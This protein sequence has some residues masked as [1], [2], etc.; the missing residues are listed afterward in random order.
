M[1]GKHSHASLDV[2]RGLAALVVFAAHVGEV[3]FW[4]FTGLNDPVAAWV[5]RASLGAVG[6]FFALS[7]HLI[8]KS[9][10]QNIQKNGRFEPGEYLSSR[11]SR[12]YPPLIGAIAVSLVVMGL[13]RGFHL[14]GSPAV[15]YGVPG[16]LYASRTVLSMHP[17]EILA[18]LTMVG[19][20]GAV[21]GPLWSLYAE[22]QIYLLAMCAACWWRGSRLAAVLST[23]LALTAILYL[24]DYPTWTAIWG[25]GAATA[26]AG[27]HVRD[28]GM[29]WPRFLIAAGGCSYSL[30]ILHF[31][32]LLLI[33]SA[34]QNWVGRDMGRQWIVAGAAVAG[35]IAAS[36]A[37]ARVAENQRFFKAWLTR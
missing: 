22:F 8:T 10:L 16:D 7:G 37:F 9:I 1:T 26:L 25:L 13:I 23:F 33:L 15:P 36:V 2:L 30:Y 19:G 29:R 21:N 32:L 31:P 18:S 35:I 11:V 12:I 34:T 24:K 17:P 27:W 20:L 5:N 3:Y 4:R 28:G 6:V 14:P